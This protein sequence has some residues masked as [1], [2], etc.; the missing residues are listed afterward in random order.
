MHT[1]AA[2]T[3][4]AVT[5]DHYITRAD[6][7]IVTNSLS[8]CKAM[9]SPH[10]LSL[11]SYGQLLTVTVMMMEVAFT[12]ARPHNNT[13][14]IGYFM[15]DDLYRAAAINLAIDQAQNDGLLV[16]Y[17]FRYMKL[18]GSMSSALTS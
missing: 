10:H 15:V 14:R 4:A 17:N 7:Q 18:C 16:S 8:S 9:A 1:V 12:T 11:T 3:T 5:D 6:R 13:I 2:A